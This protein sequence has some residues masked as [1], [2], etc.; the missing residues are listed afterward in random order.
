MT[1]Q[2]QAPD[3]LFGYDVL[4]ETGNKIGSVDNVWVDTATSKLEFVGVTTG[5]LFGKQHAIPAEQAQIDDTNRTMTIPYS[6]DLIKDAPSFSGDGELSPDDEEQIYSHFG[7]ARSTAPS[8]TG[9]AAGTD[10]GTAQTS[11][12]GDRSMKLSEEELQ[13]GKRPVQEGEVRLRKVV[14][15]EREEVPVDLRREDVEIERV[16]ASGNAPSGA[17]QE[18]EISVPVMHE[19]P[20]VAKEAHVKGEVRATKTAD[21]ERQTVGGEV[22]REEVEVDEEGD[23]DFED[24]PGF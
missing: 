4:D 21:T 17:F 11:D 10:T 20:V 18:Q 2:T 1:T 14:R 6:Q 15:T 23:T 24:S 9:Y 22:R 8:P 3:R 16:P 7:I 5:W 13:V 19:E 12:T